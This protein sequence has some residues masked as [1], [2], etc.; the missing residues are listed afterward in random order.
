VKTKVCIVVDIVPSTTS[1]HSSGS[2]PFIGFTLFKREG[3]PHCSFV[4]ILTRV[5]TAH[6]Y[7]INLHIITHH[8]IDVCF[9]FLLFKHAFLRRR[10]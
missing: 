4:S 5:Q 3:I 8:H 6:E 7:N 2:R 10:S 9:F 1:G